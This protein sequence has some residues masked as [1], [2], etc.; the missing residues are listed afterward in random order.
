MRSLGHGLT[1]I[2]VILLSGIGF[3]Y[4]VEGSDAFST[5]IVKIHEDQYISG[6][7]IKHILINS[8]ST[9]VK[10]I[11]HSQEDIWIELTGEVSEKMKESFTL[12]V[13]E[14]NGGLQVDLD[15]KSHPSFTVFAI[16]KGTKLVVHIPAKTYGDI[17]VE[18]TSGDIISA[19]LVSN[20]ITIHSKSGDIKEDTL[21]GLAPPIC[22]RNG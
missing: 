10:I 7:E 18:S 20:H 22:P 16:N 17:K 8:R 5:K 4:Y 19:N 15:R 13:E 11:P 9:D 12:T 6:K 14:H 1:L 2:G 21:N 3:I